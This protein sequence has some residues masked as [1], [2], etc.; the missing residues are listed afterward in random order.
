MHLRWPGLVL[1][2]AFAL[3][4]PGCVHSGPTQCYFPN[5]YSTPCAEELAKGNLEAAEAHCDR[6]IARTPGYA[7]FWHLKGL[8]AVVREDWA[9]ARGHLATALRYNP[10]HFQA[11]ATLG[12]VFMHEGAHDQAEKSFRE[13]LA[14]NP[15]SLD[16]RYNLALALM[17]QGRREESRKELHSI[18]SDSSG[19]ATAASSAAAHQALGIIDYTERKL[20]GAAA[21]LSQA[22]ML[23]P[24][25]LESW[26][27][28]GTVLKEQGRLA[29]AA[30]A[31]G[32][33][34]RLDAK[35]AACREGQEA[36]RPRPPP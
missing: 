9:A 6:G 19:Q 24:D 25:R 21:H 5:E 1:S 23:A 13:A 7:E 18:L 8:I 28:L 16:G 30:E 22:V 32:H 3:L 31:F 29:D 12:V 20:E 36:T 2:C 15:D 26:H 11:H 17:K 34:L 4:L 33:C 27:D 14:V 10:Y 35:R